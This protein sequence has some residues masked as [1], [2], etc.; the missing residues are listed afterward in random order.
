MLPVAVLAKRS[1][2]LTQVIVIVPLSD[3]TH[4]HQNASTPTLNSEDF[5]QIPDENSLILIAVGGG[6]GGYL[7]VYV[8]CMHVEHSFKVHKIYVIQ[9]IYHVR[10]C[11]DCTYD[12]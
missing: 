8:C 6:K 10:R 11:F 2:F 3:V 9:F 4:V 12:A 5:M 1:L 7:L